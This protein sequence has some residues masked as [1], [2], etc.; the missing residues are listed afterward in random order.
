MPASR[1]KRSSGPLFCWRSD[2]HLGGTSERFSFL[3]IAPPFT[4]VCCC[5]FALA[6]RMVVT[7]CSFQSNE[8][9]VVEANILGISALMLKDLKPVWA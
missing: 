1:A 2:L 4:L 6:E 9:L 8:L 5:V 7:A 3:L